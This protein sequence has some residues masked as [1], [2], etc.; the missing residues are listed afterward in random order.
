MG[1]AEREAVAREVAALA[2]SPADYPAAS[3]EL[4]GKG[5]ADIVMATMAEVAVVPNSRMLSGL[6]SY[7]RR[8]PHQVPGCRIF[9]SSSRDL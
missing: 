6:R 7:D 2:R 5:S 1:S 8:Q 3:I 4:G 9:D